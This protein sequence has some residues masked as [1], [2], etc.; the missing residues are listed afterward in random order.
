LERSANSYV[1][2][3]IAARLGFALM[4]RLQNDPDGRVFELLQRH[5]LGEGVAVM[6]LDPES[7]ERFGCQRGY[8]RS[9]GNFRCSTR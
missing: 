7:S 4:H 3:M 6:Y 9:A 5:L 1:T 8:Q 2:Q